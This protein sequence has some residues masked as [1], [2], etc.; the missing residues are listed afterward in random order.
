MPDPLPFAPGDR[1]KMTDRYA[2]TLS[3]AKGSKTGIWIGRVGTVRS[4]NSTAVCIVWDG[5]LSLD[6]VPLRAIERAGNDL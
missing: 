3:K 2:T 5:R 1:V 6:F 4:C